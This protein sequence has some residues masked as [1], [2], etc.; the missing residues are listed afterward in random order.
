MDISFLGVPNKNPMGWI[1]WSLAFL[2]QGLVLFPAAMYMTR[3][4]RVL[5][6][7]KWMPGAVSLVASSI[8]MVL[9]GLIPQFRSL[10]V[11]H[12]VSGVL[13]MGGLYMGLVLWGYLFF[14]EKR[15]NLILFV[16]FAFFLLFGPIGF[17]ST[18]GYRFIMAPLSYKIDDPACPWFLTFSIW[19]WVL[20]AGV[21]FAYV[22]CLYLLCGRFSAV[23]NEVQEVELRV[24]RRIASVSKVFRF[25]VSFLFLFVFIELGCYMV[26]RIIF[27]LTAIKV[28][29]NLGV[30]L[31][32]VQFDGKLKIM[33]YNICHGW[34]GD[35]NKFNND[36]YSIVKRLDEISEMLALEKPDI[37]VL[38]EVDFDSLLS[39]RINQGEYLAKKAGYPFWIE[40]K[41]IDA[42]TL[43]TFSEQG[44][45]LVLSRN[46]I[47]KAELV[48]FP[49]H[50]RWE[51]IM[52]GKSMAVVCEIEI[53]GGPIL[54]LLA[55][56]LTSF[57]EE[58]RVASAKIIELQRN[59][60]G[61]PFLIVGDFN[62]APVG[63]PNHRLFNNEN[64][65]DFLMGTGAYVTLPISNPDSSEFTISVG[66]PSAIVDW[67]LVPFSWKIISKQVLPLTVSDH[68]PLMMDVQFQW[69]SAVRD[70]GPL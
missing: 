12:I 18:Q 5:Y 2:L 62:S 23:I 57:S 20:L 66:K 11:I 49:G 32:P 48:V 46:P 9:L 35:K 6:P 67:I 65:M 25:G 55:T 39:G 45:N 36:K 69:S 15:I 3:Q 41:N 19:E 10:G 42:H 22:I 60:S 58:I 17:L 1:I 21:F 33:T 50:K 53:V 26:G 16:F 52:G 37:V 4:M 31:N 30:K 28:R 14:L 38:E 47:R 44:G 68:Y 40:Q 7:Q 61:L 43:L 70:L 56:H 51:T 63:I 27:P 29:E 24:Q 13:A 34:G 54:R 8:G 64:A 59:M